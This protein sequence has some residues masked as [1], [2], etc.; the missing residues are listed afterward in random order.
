MV[1]IEQHLITLLYLLALAT[2]V[3]V[4]TERYP[5]IQNTTGLLLIGIV[6]SAVGS[7][8][9]VE[10][11]SELILLI[12]L[13]ALVF[14]DA[15]N[16]DVRA[17]RD[18]LGSILALSIVGLL[19]SIAIIAVVGP[20]L[21]G[22]PLAVAIL[23][24]AIIMPTDP[25]SVLTVFER[26][27]VPERLHI[28]VEGESLLNDGVSIVVY[29][30]VLTALLETEAQSVALGE[31]LTIWGLLSTI[32][33]GI[34]IAMIGGFIVG[35]VAGYAAYELVAVIDDEMTAVVISLLLAYGV[36][37]FL[38]VLG[39][40]GVIGTLTAGVFFASRWNRTD[41]SLETH[42][43]VET[44]W[45]VL[46][47]LADAILFVVI[48]IV[49]PLDL[50][51]EYGM[52]ILGAIAVVFLARALVIYPLI[53]LL[54]RFQT[55]K[56]PYS[57]QHVLTWSGIHASVSIALVLGVT[58]V[59]PGALSEQLYALVFGVATFTLLVNGQTMEMLVNRLRINQ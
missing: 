44:T 5:R 52:Q 3:G 48:G 46:D 27:S 53:G 54:N 24:G 1:S 31:Q 2:V 12:V 38:D 8:I 17:F 56:I 20:V 40:S 29:S 30:A 11:T 42:S 34:A 26:L 43:I 59:F 50:L 15:V 41:I 57:Y 6:V 10:L 51:V 19:L 33:V 35:T 13:P 39:S 45:S 32:A 25:V 4:L 23:F 55:T 28:L 36:Y 18:N 7:P 16:I 47:F 37:V 9:E 14:N 22:F 21:F 49:T 58:E